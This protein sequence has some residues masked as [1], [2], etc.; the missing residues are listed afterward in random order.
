VLS[1]RSSACSQAAT[2]SFISLL[3][4]PLSHT[5]DPMQIRAK[6]EKAAAKCPDFAEL[7]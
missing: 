4:V 6:H 2:N 7:P 5:S 3:H 1:E